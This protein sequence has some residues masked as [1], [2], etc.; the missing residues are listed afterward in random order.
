[1]AGRGQNA[2]EPSVG[3]APQ[4]KEELRDEKSRK[5]EWVQAQRSPTPLLSKLKIKSNHI[6]LGI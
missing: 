5:D 2:E 4:T 1:V 6:V 3:I